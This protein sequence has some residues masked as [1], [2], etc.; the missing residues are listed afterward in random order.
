MSAERGGRRPGI[1]LDATVAALRRA[2]ARFAYLYGSQAE[3]RAGPDS[4]VDVAAWFGRDDVDP[5][6]VGAGLPSGVDLLVLDR[7]ALAVAGRVALRGRLLFDDD[8]P[9]RVAWQATTRKLYADEEPRRRQAR[10]DFAAARRSRG[11]R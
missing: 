9:A 8:P 4:D 11:R 1:D 10:A 7:A 3:G 2:G 5:F 6:A